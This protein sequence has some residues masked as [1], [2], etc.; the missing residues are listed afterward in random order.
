MQAK[1]VLRLDCEDEA[2]FIEDKVGRWMADIEPGFFLP[3]QG[4]AVVRADVEYFQT[5]TNPETKKTTVVGS[6]INTI[7]D[8]KSDLFDSD[9]RLV[10]AYNQRRLLQSQPHYAYRGVALIQ[11]VLIEIINDL[12]A[13]M[14]YES[15]K[16]KHV[17]IGVYKAISMHLPKFGMP[18][19]IEFLNDTE[20]D[21]EVTR[22]QLLE[23]ISLWDERE[24]KMTSVLAIMDELIRVL[25]QFI[26]RETWVMHFIK[27][28][29]RGTTLNI[30]KT[31]DYRI[32]MFHRDRGD[33]AQQT[34]Q[35]F[36]TA[37][38]RIEGVTAKE[39]MPGHTRTEA[40]IAD[41]ARRLRQDKA[42]EEIS[43][44]RVLT[45]DERTQ[46]AVVFFNYAPLCMSAAQVRSGTLEDEARRFD[47]MSVPKLSSQCT[48]IQLYY[49][50][51]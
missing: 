51:R 8:I 13:W 36:L 16:Q 10:L 4:P 33:L 32:Y 31:I 39:L 20:K 11:A 46:L 15:P 26:N 48:G 24:E 6:L 17:G 21:P 7:D 41:L 37:S 43:A 47:E 18:L 14:R 29:L 22:P 42:E 25:K 30:E 2:Q 44:G 45:H 27:Q 3:L 38:H 49:L 50:T 5:V 12:S 23:L 28:P 9:G 34:D 1:N 40:E 19:D 35:R